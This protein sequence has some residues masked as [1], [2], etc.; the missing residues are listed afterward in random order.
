ML[1]VH[2][3]GPCGD[4]L[5]WSVG[6]YEDLLKKAKGLGLD[7]H[8]AGQKALYKKFIPG[9]DLMKGPSILVPKV[10]HTI[11]GP[12]GIVSRTLK[13]PTNARQVLARDIKEL[14]RVYPDILSSKL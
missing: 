8:H 5:K 9:D 14:R 1:V 12:R 10:G 6:T 2:N 4:S 13:G 11:R 3:A 7:A